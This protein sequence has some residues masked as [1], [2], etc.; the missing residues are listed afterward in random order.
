MRTL[1]RTLSLQ[2]IVLTGPSRV[3]IQTT[4]HRAQKYLSDTV[5]SL[6]LSLPR[7]VLNANPRVVPSLF[8]SLLRCQSR[9]RRETFSIV[10]FPFYLFV[11]DGEVMS[12]R[13][14][15][16]SG[17]TRTIGEATRKTYD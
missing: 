12:G 13:G 4:I 17:G 16:S 5:M 7:I 3:K 14:L 8:P 9:E 10:S 6:S 1:L 15:K 11:L 2:T